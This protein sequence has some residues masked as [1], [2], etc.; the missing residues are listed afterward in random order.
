MISSEKLSEIKA[1]AKRMRVHAMKMASITRGRG[2]HIGS[3][4]SCIEILAVLY[5]S[6]M[7]YDVK[8]PCDINRDRFICSKTH[9]VLATYPVLHE[10]GFFSESVLLD[11]HEDGSPLFGYPRNVRLGLEFEGGSLGMGLSYGVGQALAARFK[12]LDYKTYV[13]LGDGELNE[14]SVWEAAASA[15]HY[16][17]A[18]LVAI[19]DRNRL[20]LDGDTEI[21][22][23][24]GDLSSKF[25]SFGWHVLLCGGHDLRE[26]LQAFSSLSGDKPTVIIAETIKGKGVS[27]MENRRE[28]H[29]SRITKEQFGM[30]MAELS[31]ELES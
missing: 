12:G 29:Q 22:M 26:L 7:K 6:V 18:N 27:F 4:L 3:S 28:W 10:A 8:N 1:I 15:A 30:A 19:I 9:A 5:F 17:L 13:L 2:A 21:V 14:G 31:P 24:L 20:C 11:Y 25:A 23:A 16:K